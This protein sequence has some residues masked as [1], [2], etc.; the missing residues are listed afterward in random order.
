M[1]EFNELKKHT[2]QNRVIIE[3]NEQIITLLQQLTGKGEITNDV[4]DQAKA[5]AKHDSTRSRRN[6]HK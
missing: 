4:R 2:E 6:V 1:L 5:S 3:Q